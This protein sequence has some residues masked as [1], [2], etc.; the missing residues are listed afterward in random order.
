MLFH[1]LIEYG[2][3]NLV[4]NRILHAPD[5]RFGV[6]LKYSSVVKYNPH[7]ITTS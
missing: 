6:F 5:L 4:V 7:F 2:I 3:F 1:P